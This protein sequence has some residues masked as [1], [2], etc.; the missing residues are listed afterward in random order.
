LSGN[1]TTS[2]ST[3]GNAA[4]AT[5]LQ[6]A[7]TIGGVSFDGTANISLPGVDTAGNQDTSGNA[8]TATSATTATTAT[9]ANGLNTGND[10]QVNSLGVGTAGSATTG[11]IRATDNIT[12]YYSSDARLKENVAPIGD[13]LDKLDMIRGVTYDW[14][15]S[16]IEAKGG[17][18]GYFVRKNDVGVIAQEIERVLPQL[19]AENNQGFKAVRYERLVALLI[20]AVK[21]LRAEVKALKGE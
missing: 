13:A 10:Y 16:Y 15:D 1:A 9:T 18:D 5:A 3:T 21:E 6:T 8:A 12:A 19:V 11:E 14:T 7:R 20:E 4:T 2:S 17:E